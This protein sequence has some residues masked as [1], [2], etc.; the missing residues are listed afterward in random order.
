MYP[1]QCSLSKDVTLQCCCFS[2]LPCSMSGCQWEAVGVRGGRQGSGEIRQLVWK[3]CWKP[4]GLGIYFSLL[5]WSLRGPM[6]KGWAQGKGGGVRWWVNKAEVHPLAYPHVCF[7]PV[8]LVPL[9]V[10]PPSCQT[11]SYGWRATQVCTD[12]QEAHS[13]WPRAEVTDP[14]DWWC[15][16]QCPPLQTLHSFYLP[17]SYVGQL[18]P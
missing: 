5:S 9:Q 8:S 17:F 13:L 11:L 4:A 18:P 15:S 14:L 6:G 7:G 1:K 16:V 12:L 10:L 2:C 3:Y